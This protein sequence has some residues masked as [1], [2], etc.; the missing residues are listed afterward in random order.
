MANR[1]LLFIAYYMPPMGSS[2]VQRPFNLLAKLPA[3]GWDPIIL[4]PETGVYHT[5]DYS[6]GKRFDQLRLPVIR[7]TSKTP[8]HIFGGKAR[9]LEPSSEKI[10][11]I[12]RW[13]SAFFFLP[14]NKKAW[15]NPAITEGRKIIRQH[16]PDLILAT[17]PPPSNL[18]IA[19]KLASEFNIPL[20]FDMR[21]DWLDNHQHIYPSRFHRSL[22]A[23]IE[24]YT[25]PM[26]KAIV[27]VNSVIQRAIQSRYPQSKASFYTI[28]SGF[29]PQVFTHKSSASLTK[30]DAKYTFLYS[31]RFYGEN[32]PNV[33]L[34]AVSK[35][36]GKHPELKNRITLA[37]QGGLDSE[38]LSLI[39][40]LG[41]SDLVQNLG[42]CEHDVAV[43]NLSQADAL[44][45]T[46]AHTYKADQVSTGKVTEYMGSRKPILALA[47]KNGA[48]DT[49]LSGYGPSYL[50]DPHRDEAVIPVLKN[51]INDMMDGTLTS[52]NENYV[53]MFT[54][55]AMATSFVRV[56]NDT[57]L[58]K[59][60]S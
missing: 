8:F 39:Q 17:S 54:V 22:M 45:L 18:I 30:K 48:L 15:I 19:S 24:A 49:L 31:G 47:P 56:F 53:N 32:Q 14:D 35:L 1:K 10:S 46:A 9:V 57:A 13:F 38:H 6:L 27:S 34:I 11:K 28:P 2:G 12:L 43:A 4:C 5:L 16:S 29:D 26:A 55:D 40:T 59:Q 60:T 50:A 36:L 41:L 3:M 7:V 20:V 33:F 25:M 58:S 23:K 51:L 42:Y 52:V 21:D 37:F 44:W